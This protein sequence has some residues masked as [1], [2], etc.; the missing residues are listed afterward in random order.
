MANIYELTADLLRLQAMLLTADEENEAEIAEALQIA[1]A[2]LEG[3][4]EGYAHV[5]RNIEADISAL[6]AEEQRLNAKRKTAE[7]AAERLK[8]TLF[9]AMVRTGKTKIKAGTF[10]LKIAQNGG[11]LPVI[12]DVPADELPSELVKVKKEADKAAIAEYIEATGDLTYAHYGERG[13]SLRIR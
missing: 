4:A 2:E 7:K 8:N 9:E 11:A 1:D 5:I 6:K 3:K 10:D 13:A 12:L